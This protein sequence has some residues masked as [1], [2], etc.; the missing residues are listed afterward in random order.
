MEA[1]H[2]LSAVEKARLFAGLFPQYL[3]GLVG[4][5]GG[6]C[7]YMA[8]NEKE[9]KATWDNPV[10]GAEFW[11]RIAGHIAKAIAQHGKRLWKSRQLF[12]E[13]LFDGYNALFS[14]DCILKYKY[15]TGDPKFVQAVRLFFE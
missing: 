8:A 3:E 15:A 14:V 12:A 10:F 13:E 6:A 4:A 5:I 2:K 1:L 11:Y 7:A 9:I